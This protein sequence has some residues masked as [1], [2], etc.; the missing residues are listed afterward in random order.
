MNEQHLPSSAL[1]EGPVPGGP[2]S[3]L[4]SKNPSVSPP[5]LTPGSGPLGSVSSPV[6]GPSVRSSPCPDRGGLESGTGLTPTG[7]SLTWAGPDP[8]SGG[9]PWPPG[10][11][12][13]GSE[14]PSGTAPSSGGNRFSA[15][16]SGADRKWAGPG[17]AGWL[18]SA[19]VAPAA[20]R[21][22]GGAG[23]S[24]TVS[25]RF[26]AGLWEE[27]RGPPPAGGAEF[28]CPGPAPPG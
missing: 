26:M 14:T 20:D 2:A 6:A 13:P 28:S 19:R 12:G 16:P 5:T 23:S 27:R 4:D 1:T 9:V 25:E 21:V 7:V 8:L 15:P 10:L 11:S 22:W 3:P 17:S 24:V 18:R